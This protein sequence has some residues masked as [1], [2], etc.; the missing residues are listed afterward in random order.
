[1]GAPVQAAAPA[2]LE[3]AGAARGPILARVR[4]NLRALDEVLG[5][6]SPLTRL[7]VEGGWYAT[8]RLPRVASLATRAT[9]REVTRP[10][11]GDD[12]E[13]LDED[14]AVDLLE[15][16]GV[17][18]HPGSFFELDGAHVVLSLLTE[19]SRFRAGTLALRRRADA[20]LA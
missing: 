5:S 4:D 10:H 6:T 12:H 9:R 14:F 20:A 16:D 17:Y 1:V 11:P 7:H 3:E 2:L 8:L 15:R 13:R 18:V 19:P